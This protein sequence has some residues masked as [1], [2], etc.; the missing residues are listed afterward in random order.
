LS[1]RLGKGPQNG[2]PGLV[3]RVSAGL[4]NTGRPVRPMRSAGKAATRLI[5]PQDGRHGDA[6]IS[7]GGC[8]CQRPAPDPAEASWGGAALGPPPKGQAGARNSARPE[9]GSSGTLMETGF[10]NTRGGLP[11]PPLTPP[12][13]CRAASGACSG[14]PTP[15]EP[16]G[17]SW[18][19][20]R[21]RETA[22]DKNGADAFWRD[23]EPLFCKNWSHWP[24]HRRNK[25]K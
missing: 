3:D 15:Q 23:L 13:P 24:T 17:R 22:P 14:R 11:A 25:K 8:W 7:W 6:R 1:W 10:V 5:Q 2:K 20:E 16:A 9:E 4:Q 12:R 18:A 21:P 19:G